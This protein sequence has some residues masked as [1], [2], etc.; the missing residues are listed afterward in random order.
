M[1]N[2]GTAPDWILKLSLLVAVCIYLDFYHQVESPNWLPKVDFAGRSTSTIYS[3]QSWEWMSYVSCGFDSG[4]H[5]GMWKMRENVI[6]Y[7]LILKWWREGGGEKCWFKRK[8]FQNFLKRF[9]LKIN[10][11]IWDVPCFEGFPWNT[12]MAARREHG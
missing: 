5:H 4:S 10:S 6:R 7:N 2:T 1:L 11:L 9:S 12:T 8:T 3:S